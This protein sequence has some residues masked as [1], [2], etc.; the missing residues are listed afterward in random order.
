MESKLTIAIVQDS[1]VFNDLG[2]TLEKASRLAAE[3]AR[4]GAQLIVFGETWFAGYPAWLDV[5]PE[6]ALWDHPL[7]KK[8]FAQMYRNSVTVP[9]PACETLGALAKQHRLYLIA[10]VHESVV[11]GPG[12]GTLYNSILFFDPQGQLVNHHRKLMPT[13]TE[14]LVHGPGDGAGLK[15]VDTPYGPIGG[16]ICWEHWM[17]LARLAM[18]EAGEHIHFALWPKVHELLQVASRSYAFE[19]RCFVVAVGQIL[20]AADLPDGLALPPDLRADP[21]QL[22]LNGG[23][24]VIGP[25]GRYRLEPRYDLRGLIYHT[26]DDLDS[27]LQERMTLDVTG[28]YQR[29]DLFTFSVDRR[30]S[31]SE[32]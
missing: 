22:V 7:T 17:P 25:D 11:R 9:G 16:L 6:A 14:R 3:A 21:S 15:T 26:F 30:R 5:C 10:G 23:S 8:V 28:H 13:F 12:N 20:A 4:E 19:G 1:P 27:V 24:A 29:P 18:H 32:Q 31:A 2:A